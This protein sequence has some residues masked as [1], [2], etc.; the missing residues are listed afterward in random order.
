MTNERWMFLT[1]HAHTLLCLAQD[2]CLRTRD[3][4]ARLGITERAVQKI[5]AELVESGY[6]EKER[7]GRRNRYRLVPGQPMGHPM[8]KHC[9]LGDI[10]HLVRDSLE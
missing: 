3:L 8:E 7:M 4:A 6:L 9:K 10:L 5:V 2:P 1:N